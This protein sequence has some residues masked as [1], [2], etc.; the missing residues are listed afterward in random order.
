VKKRFDSYMRR[1][2]LLWLGLGIVL[3]LLPQAASAQGEFPDLC[4]ERGDNLIRNCE[5]N[6]GMSHWSTFVE[7][8]NPSFN[9]ASAWP[10]CDSP[11]CPA[12]RIV[13][14]AA[15]IGGIYQQVGGVTP[16]MEYWANVIWLVYTPGGKIDGTVGRSIGI[17]PTGGTDPKSPNVVWGQQIWNKFDTCSYKICTE[18]QVKAI[19]QSDT[20]TVF[21]RIEDTWK[22]R[23]EDFN[24][25]PENFFNE[26]EF[27]WIDDVG[28]VGTGEAP[29]PTETPAPEP[30][31]TPEPPPT[32]TPAAAGEEE[33]ASAPAAAPAEEV[34]ETPTAAPTETLTPTATATATA[35]PTETPTPTE[36]ATATA[37]PTLTPTVMP[38]P[39]VTPTPTPEPLLQTGEMVAGG[40]FCMVG[41]GAIGVLLVIGTVLYWLY[42]TGVTSPREDDGAWWGGPEW[43]GDEVIPVEAEIVEEGDEPNDEEDIDAVEAEDKDA[44]EST[45]E[46]RD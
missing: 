3:F 23:R 16:G 11:K 12:M 33:V 1:A 38:T 15:Y 39:T 17:D 24:Y 35:T 41:L 7:Y 6:D 22:D 30:T 4:A 13:A 26:T 5:F 28:M 34:E 40:L 18:L 36:T 29:P 46:G 8:G 42:R 9:V 2:S 19:A 32:E 14:D 45:E 10:E 44:D 25:V 31:A 21:V 37:T 27:L 43:D 20:I